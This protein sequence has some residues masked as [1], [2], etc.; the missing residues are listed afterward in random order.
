MYPA[1]PL[2]LLPPVPQEARVDLSWLRQQRRFD[3]SLLGTADANEPADTSQLAGVIRQLADHGLSLPGQFVEFLSDE[4]L[5]SRIKTPSYC[6]VTVSKYA[7]ELQG[8]T[9]VWLVRF[10]ADQQWVLHWC[11]AVSA[12]GETEVVACESRDDE[13]WEAVGDADQVSASQIVARCGTFLEFVWRFWADG[14]CWHRSASGEEL[15]DVLAEHLTTVRLLA[16]STSAPT[17]KADW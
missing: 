6:C 2:H 1:I 17:P 13:S 10:M 14:E 15:D 3:Q 7:A 9:G 16:T 11:L 5:I 12:T 8:A 4:E